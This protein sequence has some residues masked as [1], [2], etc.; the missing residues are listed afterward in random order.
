[1]LKYI[2]FDFLGGTTIALVYGEQPAENYFV[3]GSAMYEPLH[4]CHLIAIAIT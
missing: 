3:P 4:S 1:M 2:R